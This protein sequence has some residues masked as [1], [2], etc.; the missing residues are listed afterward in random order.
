MTEGINQE[1]FTQFEAML[2]KMVANVE[3]KKEE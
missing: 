2:E 3:R 1:Q